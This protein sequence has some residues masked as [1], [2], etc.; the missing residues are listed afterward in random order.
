MRNFGNC[1]KFFAI[2][3]VY[4][5]V[6]RYIESFLNEKCEWPVKL[7]FPII[8]RVPLFLELKVLFKKQLPGIN[9]NKISIITY[10]QI[11]SGQ[12]LLILNL[13]RLQSQQ[14][15]VRLNVEFGVVFDFQLAA[16]FFSYFA[17]HQ[18]QALFAQLL[19]LFGNLKTVS[20][21]MVKC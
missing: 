14:F 6:F 12:I 1:Q 20:Y 10:F 13:L 5:E 15:F 7:N 16:H 17:F 2:W 18:V 11:V 8:W 9:Q 21:V 19:L 3:R 4:F